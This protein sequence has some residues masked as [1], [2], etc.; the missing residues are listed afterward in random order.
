MGAQD[1]ADDALVSLPD[2]GLWTGRKVACWIT[3]RIGRTVSPQR[4]VEYLR[5]LDLTRQVPRQANPKASLYE[6]G[7]FKKA[8]GPRQR[9][10]GLVQFRRQIAP[11][12]LDV[13]YAEAFWRMR[14]GSQGTRSASGIFSRAPR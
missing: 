10:P 5:R 13:D 14:S 1:V 11:R 2:G 9:A 4:R 3:G 8:P 12:R 7:R 6:Q